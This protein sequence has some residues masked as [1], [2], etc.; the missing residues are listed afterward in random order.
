M[1]GWTLPPYPY[2]L[3]EGDVDDRMGPPPPTTIPEGRGMWMIG[4]TLPPYPPP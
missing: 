1:I 2:P 3:R 4:W